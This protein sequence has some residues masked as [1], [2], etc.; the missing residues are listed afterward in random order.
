MFKNLLLCAALFMSYVGQASADFVSVDWLDNDDQ[1]TLRDNDTGLLWLDLSET[2]GMS[3]AEVMTEISDISSVYYGWRLP[4]QSEL[5]LMF[6]NYFGIEVDAETALNI[7]A[8][9]LED[10]LLVEYL[11][12]TGVTFTTSEGQYN[13]GYSLSDS[14]ENLLYSSV[15]YRYDGTS[16]LAILQDRRQSIETSSIN[17]GVYLVSDSIN[18]VSTPLTLSAL[19]IIAFWGRLKSVK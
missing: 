19:F 17:Y 16:Y 2:L 8:S 7:D 4:T 18:D 12:S 10:S 14:G 11:N 6:S 9:E 5:L 13:Y 1:A 15:A 3:L